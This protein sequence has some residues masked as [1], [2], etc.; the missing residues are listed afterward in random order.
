MM[1]F[2]SNLNVKGIDWLGPRACICSQVVLSSVIGG[3]L[4]ESICSFLVRM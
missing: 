3:I 2:L 1:R 4:E